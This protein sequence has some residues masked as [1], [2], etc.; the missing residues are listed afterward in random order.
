MPTPQA[1]LTTTSNRTCTGREPNPIWSGCRRS[2]G[3]GASPQNRCFRHAP[4]SR[5]I[6]ADGDAIREK[7]ARF[8]PWRSA[9]SPA[10]NPA[11]RRPVESRRSPGPK[12]VGHQPPPR[13]R[14]AATRTAPRPG[15]KAPGPMGDT[16]DQAPLKSFG[17][18]MWN[19]GGRKTTRA[20]HSPPASAIQGH[21]APQKEPSDAAPHPLPQCRPPREAGAR[22]ATPPK[23]C[24]CGDARSRVKQVRSTKT[25]GMTKRRIS[26]PSPHPGPSMARHPIQPPH[27]QHHGYCRQIV[28]AR[29]VNVR[30]PDWRLA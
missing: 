25:A 23:A 22:H 11:A 13:Q 1:R 9:R 16:T 6:S 2:A 21:P 28:P 15:N 29:F 17:P 27:Q 18:E 10:P 4:G 20:R 12:P 30:Y 5:P 14:P 7:A 3:K 26:P 19:P 8:R 24:P